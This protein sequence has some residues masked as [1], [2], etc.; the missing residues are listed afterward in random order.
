L[1]E[2][3]M[4]SLI[5]FDDM[6]E[7]CCGMMEE[8]EVVFKA[9]PAFEWLELMNEELPDANRWWDADNEPLNEEERELFYV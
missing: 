5:H 9:R 7:I 4:M 2:G 1:K 6:Y 8:P 3:A